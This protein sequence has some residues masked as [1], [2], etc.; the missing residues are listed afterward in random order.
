MKAADSYASLLKGVSQQVPQDRAEGQHSEQVNM[1]SD[2]VN[3]LTRRHGSVWQAESWLTS[4]SA[5]QMATYQADVANWRSYDL[6]S[7][8]KEYLVLYRTQ[9]RPA[10][11]SPLPFALVYNKTDKVFLTTVRP[12]VDAGLDNLEANGVAALTGVGKYLFMTSKGSTVTG[13]TTELWNTP[14][15]LGRAV[16]WVR[17]GAYSRTFKITVRTQAGGTVTVSHATPSSSFQGTLS[18]TDILTSDPDYVKKVNDRVNAYNSS[19]TAWIGTA[20]A[21]IQPSAIATALATLLN[22]SGVAC[23]AI[24]S[25]I[26]FTTANQVRSIEV[27]DGG[28]GSLMRGVADEVES[29]D[30][31]SPVHFVGKVVKVRSRNAQEAYY[32]QAVAKSANATGYAEV[33]WIEAAGATHSIGGGI[34]YGTVSGSSFYAASSATLLNSILPGDHPTFATSAAGDA[35]SNPMPF[36][37]GRKVTYLGTFQ[38]RLLVG[39]GGA[40]AV[41]R[42]DDYLNF[43]RSTVLT[44]PASD[45][46]EMLPQGSEDDELFHSTLYDQDLVIFGKRRQYLIS[47]TVA[48]TP[49]SANMPVM[50]SYEGVADAAPVSAGGFIFYAKRGTESSGVFQIQPGQND[51][52]PESFPASSQL[53]DYIKGGVVELASIT[54]TPS[55]L[56]LRTD[57]SPNILYTF[58]YLDRTDGRK[59]DAWGRWDFNSALGPFVGMSVVKDGL[60]T[61]SLRLSGSKVY[62]VADFATVRTGLSTRPYLDSVRPWAQVLEGTG[63]VTTTSGVQ[64]AAAFGAGSSRRFTGILLPSVATLQTNYPGEPDLQV[65]ALQTA[66]FT[67]TNPYMRDKKDRAILSG[68][69]TITKIIVAFKDSSGFSWETKYRGQTDSSV[70]YLGSSITF[71]GRLLGDPNN[72]IGVEPVTTGQYSV[73]IGRETRQYTLSLSARAWHPLTVTGLEWSGQFFNRVNRF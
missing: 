64:W 32:L 49:T 38:N 3:G 28:D 60:L 55:M 16:V 54:G 53:T 41:S 46:F 9:A 29:A 35:E 13:S 34:L 48:L 24:G 40:L 72:I 17:G 21:A 4:L 65:G 51:K 23:S 59:M 26:C 2:P 44:L 11:A 6:D 71:G 18:T 31:V 14:T 39:S 43:F 73:P 22:S 52:S 5:A 66:Y 36:F 68:R 33:T 10:G 27:D 20:T 63:S 15:N 30:R 57:A 58:T 67:P 69:L 12:A 62:A 8:G 19:V 45:P 25:H 7:G 47:G 1:I 56:M 37:V 50:S 70:E 42:T 61:V